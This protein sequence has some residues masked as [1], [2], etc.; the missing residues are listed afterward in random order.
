MTIIE[1]LEHAGLIQAGHRFSE[2]DKRLLESLSEDEAEA[3][4][5]VKRKIGEDFLKR[6]TRGSPP[7]VA[8]VF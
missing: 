2:E 3:L 4:I 6:N 5:S 1:R 7:A 8:I